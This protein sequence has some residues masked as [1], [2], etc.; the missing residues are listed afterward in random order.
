[1]CLF[2]CFECNSETQVVEMIVRPPCESYASQA[3]PLPEAVAE[4]QPDRRRLLRGVL[5]EGRLPLALHL[6][7]TTGVCEQTF[8]LQEPMPCK[9]AA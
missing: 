7:M 9:A 2:V 3:R 6:S 8:L 5:S 4:A 1:M